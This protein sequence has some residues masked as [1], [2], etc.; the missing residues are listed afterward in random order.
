LVRVYRKGDDSDTAVEKTKEFL[1]LHKK[2]PKD[3]ISPDED[4]TVNLGSYM[5][6]AKKGSGVY[7]VGVPR[8]KWETK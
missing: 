5:R 7:Y 1:K 4:D 6:F 8:D 2:T 3:Y